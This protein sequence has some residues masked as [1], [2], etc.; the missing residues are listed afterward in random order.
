MRKI[1]LFVL[2][3]LMAFGGTT[4][5]YAVAPSLTARIEQPKSP[6]NI[7]ELD[8]TV[9][10]LD[11]LERPVTV[12]CFKKSP[13]D[14]V[15]MQFGSDIAVSAGG[16]SVHC[17]TNSTVLPSDGTYLFY[18]EAYA[19]S[20]TA[21]TATVSVDYNTS[22][23]GTPTNYSKEKPGDCTYKIKFRSADDSGKTVKVNVYRSENTSFNLDSGTLVGTVN[24]GS[25]TDGELSN[26][27]GDC[28]KTYYFAVRAFDAAGNGSGV[29]GDSEIRTTTTS[30]ASA[31]TSSAPSGNTSGALTAGNTGNVLGTEDAITTPQQ[32]Q[33][34]G[35]S[36]PAAVEEYRETPKKDSDTKAFLVGFGVLALLIVIWLLRKRK[37][38]PTV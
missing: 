7:N 32:G 9:V 33:V 2:G 8:I 11:R 13:S 14:G 34:Q 21:T 17:E 29:V 12:R 22:G 28:N 19:G 20:D 3:C 18:A 23:P 24:I 5:V 30:N 31:G 35:E 6:T 25:N 36:T 38:S 4:G 27:V 1:F 10:T 26:T 15:F 16:N 37:P